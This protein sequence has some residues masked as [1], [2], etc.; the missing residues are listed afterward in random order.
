MPKNGLISVEFPSVYDSLYTLNS[1]CVLSSAFPCGTYCEIVNSKM[2]II[3]PNGNLLSPSLAYQFLMTNITNPNLKLSTYSFVITTQFNDNIY[4]KLLISR[5]SFACP[6]ISVISVKTCTTFEVIIG[7]QN[8][9]F[10]TVYEISLICPSYIKEAS[11]LQIFLNWNPD[12]VQGVCTSGTD[13]LYSYQCAVTQQYQGAIQYTYLS[14]YLK[15]ISPQKLI[16]IKA[17]IKNGRI[18]TYSLVANVSYKG[19]T[20]LSTNS[21]RFFI[22]SD[23]V[24]NLSNTQ[25]T[26]KNYP[27]N[28]AENAIYTLTI[29]KPAGNSVSSISDINI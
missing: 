3:R 24:Q 19:F 14:S 16:S 6:E 18:G 15:A 9:F 1:Q 8:A 21:N 29:P 20:Y 7:A 10:E 23:T 26:L 4:Y 27:I 22:N 5:S 2:L 25:M 17:K 13:S 12:P 11:E 28:R